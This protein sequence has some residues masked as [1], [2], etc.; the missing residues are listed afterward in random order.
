MFVPHTTRIEMV[1]ECFDFHVGDNAGQKWYVEPANRDWPEMRFIRDRLLRPSDLVVDCGCHHGVT[2]LLFS[3]WLNRRGRVIAFDANPANALIAQK[4]IMLNRCENAE[5][6]FSAVGNANG[7]TAIIPQSNARVERTKRAGTIRVP[8][9]RLDDFLG[10]QGPDL[11]KMDVEG[12]EIE[13]L[14]GASAL[15]ACRRTRLAIEVHASLLRRSGDSAE[16]IF[17]ILRPDDYQFWIGIGNECSTSIMPFAPG[18]D[19][20][21]DATRF[22]L[23]AAPKVELRTKS[24]PQ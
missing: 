10:S 13:V 16:A 4:N 18:A 24:N 5:I 2:T 7:F 1:G 21:P 20:A 6:H 9:T 23:F 8:M 22:Y 12:H 15:L 14:R 3:R 19:A 11:I 17:E